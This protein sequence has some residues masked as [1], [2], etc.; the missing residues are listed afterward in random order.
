MQ[1]KFKEA[2][3]LYDEAQDALSKGNFAEYAKRIEWLGKILS[4]E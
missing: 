2:T 1:D 3:R 4:K